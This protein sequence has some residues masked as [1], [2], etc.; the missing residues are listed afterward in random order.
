KAKDSGWEPVCQLGGGAPFNFNA[1]RDET[2]LSEGRLGVGG[3]LYTNGKTIYLYFKPETTFTSGTEYIAGF[4]TVN[5]YPYEGVSVTERLK[6]L[7]YTPLD[8]NLAP[9][10][11]YNYVKEDPMS[12]YK[13]TQKKK[14]NPTRYEAKMGLDK[15]TEYSYHCYRK[16]TYS[17][18]IGYYTTYNPYRAIRDIK[19]KRGTPKQLSLD[20][21]MSSG[22]YS[23]AA[24]PAYVSMDFPTINILTFDSRNEISKYENSNNVIDIGENTT[25]VKEITVARS[26]A[27]LTPSM[28]DYGHEETSRDYRISYV[29]HSTPNED[30]DFC[31]FDMSILRAQNLYVTIGT[32]DF[33]EPIKVSDIALSKGKPF[34]ASSGYENVREFTDQYNMDGHSIS[35]PYP[36]ADNAKKEAAKVFLGVK[37]DNIEEKPYISEIS[38]N[39]Y[40]VPAKNAE[41]KDLSNEEKNEYNKIVDDQAIQQAIGTGCGELVMRNTAVNVGDAWYDKRGT[42]NGKSCTTANYTP[43][44]SY[45]AV[46]RTS[47]EDEAITGVL[48]Y[49]VKNGERPGTTL[50]IGNIKYK[51]GGEALKTIDGDCYVYY[52]N[53]KFVN[54][55]RPITDISIDNTPYVDDTFNVP[56]I[57][58]NNK[59]YY[60]MSTKFIFNYKSKYL[61]DG[62]I[63]KIYVAEADTADEAK[64]ELSR[65]GANRIIDVDFNRGT[66]GKCIYVGFSTLSKEVAI[67]YIEDIDGR[68]E[69]E[70]EEDWF[71]DPDMDPDEEAELREYIDNYRVV[72]DVKCRSYYKS[73]TPLPSFKQD[74]KTYKLASNSS[75]NEGCSGKATKD[76][77]IYVTNDYIDLVNTDAGEDSRDPE[78]IVDSALHDISVCSGD[79]VPVEKLLW[80]NVVNYDGSHVDVNGSIMGCSTVSKAENMENV[81]KKNFSDIRLYLFARRLNSGI[82]PEN[83][84]NTQG[85]SQTIFPAFDFYMIEDKGTPIAKPTAD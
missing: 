39:Y 82:K 3:A 16:G 6:R 10:N 79:I 25:C 8:V 2:A 78:G 28:F 61:P 23:Y 66:D 64:L 72:Y 65:K 63:H 33:G 85:W 7:G 17:S 52:T 74:G 48:R 19:I 36:S 58:E 21:T 73:E 44:A 1:R 14:S 27:Y 68:T 15:Y 62:V 12:C 57:D 56:S 45:M 22:G 46:K 9:E 34:A 70:L 59:T 42:Y 77:Y 47:D 26:N 20:I 67:E 43:K 31:K 81:T 40:E 80:E 55:G 29:K 71:S 13:K 4:A 18:A 32:D 54:S 83:A 35:L 30:K 37:K 50:K 38:A 49:I 75:L 84:I 76:I 53:S 69:E 41:G 24:C 5:G 60:D 11:C 51:R